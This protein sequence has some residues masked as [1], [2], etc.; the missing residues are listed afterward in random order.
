MIIPGPSSCFRSDVLKQ[1]DLESG[2][3]TEDFDITMQIHRYK[4]GKIQ[5]IPEAKVYTQDPLNTKDLYDQINRWYRGYF[6]VI[7]ERRVPFGGSIADMYFS[8]QFMQA[9]SIVVWYFLIIPIT[10]VLTGNATIVAGVFLVEVFL[11]FA[12]TLLSGSLIGRP[13]I[14]RSFPFILMYRWLNLVTF[15][16]AFFDI[17]LLNKLPM[18]KKSYWATEGRRY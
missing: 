15:V 4:L 8:H 9:I 7:K 5:F 17:V 12:M 18:K 13:E 11:L 10:A 1:I 16:V 2:S 14:I 3:L 6:Q